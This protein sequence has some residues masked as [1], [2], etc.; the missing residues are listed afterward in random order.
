MK[1]I[2]LNLLAKYRTRTFN[3][4]PGRPLASPADALEYVNARGFVFFWPIK[5][6][7]LPSL[8]VAVAG[9]RPVADEHD[10]PGHVTW[11]WKDNALDRKVWYYAK[12]LRRKATMIS[13][14]V[15]PFFYA[16]S[17]NYG[18]P[19]E[20]YLIA[21]DEGRLTLAAKMVYESLLRE[22]RLNTIDLRRAA[23]LTSRSS[24]TEFN[25]ALE[26]LQ[27]DFKI[28][29]VGVSDA[30]A[31]HYAHIY[32]LTTRQ[33]PELPERARVIT[34]VE[35]RRKL[36]GL[37]IESVGA[38]KQH[39]AER[40]FGWSNSIMTRALTGLESKGQVVRAIR[41]TSTGDWWAIPT[42]VN[43]EVS[44]AQI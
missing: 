31:W 36:L 30:G 26:S 17:E 32:D 39:D 10:D 20:D 44:S 2:D 8:W 24:D 5:G 29:P 27:V 13:Q 16:L 14:D 21:Y 6:I 38:F 7:D 37:Y 41:P 11:S 3:L 40:L 25:R 35:A 9:E 33:Y 12:I 43:D 19:E 42:L 22:G 1:Q 34:E 18:N 28:L 15:A 23:R 4:P